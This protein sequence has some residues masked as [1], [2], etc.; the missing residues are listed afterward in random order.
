[1]PKENKEIIISYMPKE[2]NKKETELLV[3]KSKELGNWKFMVFGK[4]V[5]PTDFDLVTISSLL[6]KPSNKIIQ[7]RNPFDNEIS[8]QVL[9]EEKTKG[10]DVF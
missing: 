5:P 4:G 1:M 8:V 10:R 6:N 3:F 9:L 2:L 7:F